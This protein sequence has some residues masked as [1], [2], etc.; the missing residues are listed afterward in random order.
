VSDTFLKVHHILRSQPWEEKCC[1]FKKIP[2]MGILAPIVCWKM[3]LITCKWWR[4]DLC[5]HLVTT[6]SQRHFKH[7]TVAHSQHL[8]FPEHSNSTLKKFLDVVKQTLNQVRI[9]PTE[10][11][12]AYLL[13]YKWP[14]SFRVFNQKF[15]WISDFCHACCV[16]Y[17]CFDAD[18][19]PNI[20]G[21][22]FPEFRLIAAT[23]LGFH[24]LTLYLNSREKW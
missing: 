7:S 11:I 23:A 22:C 14:L 18:R 8:G 4:K 1:V 2:E 16:D 15:L 19:L 20:C 17:S 5:Y 12:I 3:T 13:N 21:T 9:W 10:E 6:H 24:S